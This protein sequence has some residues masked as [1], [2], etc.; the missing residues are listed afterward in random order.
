MYNNLTPRQKDELLKRVLGQ[1]VDP[2]MAFCPDCKKYYHKI[3]DP[4]KLTYIQITVKDENGKVEEKQAV[5]CDRQSS[6]IR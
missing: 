5:S 4:H 3:A 6:K 2:N 1:G